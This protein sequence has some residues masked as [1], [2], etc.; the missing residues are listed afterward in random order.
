MRGGEAPRGN[1]SRARAFGARH[2]PTATDRCARPERSRGAEHRDHAG[3]RGST[4]SPTPAVE[5]TRVGAAGRARAVAHQRDPTWAGD[6][7]AAPGVGPAR[8][9]P[10]PAARHGLR[11]RPHVQ[12]DDAGISTRRKRSF[13]WR[14]GRRGPAGSNSRPRPDD[15]L[16]SA[17]LSLCDD[18]ARELC[19]REIWN[20][21][22]DLGRRRPIDRPQGRRG[23][24]TGDP[25]GQGRPHRVA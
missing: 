14:H 6:R 20:R 13:G 21:F 16:R 5:A 18:V 17:D 19:L 10:W 11:P 4:A 9:G 12:P 22:D 2:G 15:P 24:A 23:R 25:I 3:T 1:V 7:H 8:H